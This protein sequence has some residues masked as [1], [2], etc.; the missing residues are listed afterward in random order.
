[1]LNMLSMLNLS[2]E[3]DGGDSGSP[4]AEPR[5]EFNTTPSAIVTGQG[6]AG[7]LLFVM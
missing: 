1:M 2:R 6:G 4:S 7:T 5:E 3:S